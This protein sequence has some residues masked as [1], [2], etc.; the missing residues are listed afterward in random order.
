[1]VRID[2]INFKNLIQLDLI[3]EKTFSEHITNFELI[4]FSPLF[5]EF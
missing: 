3:A 4:F 2:L 5:T 1:M